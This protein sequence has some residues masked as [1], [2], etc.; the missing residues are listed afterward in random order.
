LLLTAAADASADDAAT[1][2]DTSAS[3]NSLQQVVVRAR[4]REEPIEETPLA[5]TALSGEQLQ[6]QSALVLG[7]VGRDVPNTRM[8][9]SPA[10]PHP[11]T[12]HPRLGPHSAAGPALS[13][14]RRL[15]QP[16]AGTHVALE[17]GPFVDTGKVYSAMGA[18]PVTHLHAAGVPGGARCGQAVRRGVRARRLW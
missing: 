17:V 3:D 13:A 7:D 11:D 9:A 15:R 16:R 10:D 5:I 18:N 12:R 8:V 6:Q 2:Q 14:I 4:R 1:L